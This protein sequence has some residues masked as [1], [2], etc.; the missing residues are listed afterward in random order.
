MKLSKEKLYRYTVSEDIA[1][2]VSH[3][4][5]AIFAYIGLIY[6]VYT[7]SVNGNAVDV[8]AYAI[9]G[10]SLIT[11]FLM[12]TLYHSIFHDMTRSIF[13]RLDHSAIFILITGTYVPYT[14]VALGSS[15]AYLILVVMVL[16]TI[17]GITLKVFFI[18]RFKKIGTIVY[19]AMGWLVIFEF[20]ALKEAL[21]YE[22]MFYLIAGGV[23]YT[24]GAIIYAVSK[25]KYHHFIWHLFVFA[26]AI[27][28]F[29]SIAF[30][31]L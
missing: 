31:L 17:L 13:K 7:A 26:A 12:S 23:I 2:G 4:I 27:C 25:F 9:Y 18:E 1:N 14:V 24:I 8:V 21:S 28:H 30:Y 10:T 16:L 22:A 11:M 20:G 29:I 5:G 19:V 3:G 6:L 15:T